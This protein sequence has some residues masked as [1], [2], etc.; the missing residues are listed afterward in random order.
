MHACLLCVSVRSPS[1]LWLCHGI[2]GQSACTGL[3]YMAAVLQQSL[4]RMPSSEVNDCDL[5]MNS[6]HHTILLQAP[7]TLQDISEAKEAFLTSG[8]L[9]VVGI[10]NW[11]G[12]PIGD[13]TVGKSTIVLRKLL[14]DD[15][16][17][18]KDVEASPY[19]VWVPYGR[20]T[21]MVSDF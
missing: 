15:M 11:R 20:A 12:R 14:M 1:S 3:A 4:H 7:V 16:R 8:T 10:T 9:P 19:H 2:T 17:P 5:A 13:G 6:G 21:G 18:P